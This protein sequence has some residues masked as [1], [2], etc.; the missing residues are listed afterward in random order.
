M[1]TQAFLICQIAVPGDVGRQA[2]ELQDLP[3]LHGDPVAGAGA[4]SG[5]RPDA[6]VRSAAIGVGPG[7][8]G[9]SQDL[10][11]GQHGRPPPLQVPAI[12]PVKRA[13]PQADVVADQVV[14]D[15]PD[16]ADLVVLVEDQADDLA[17]LL[18]GVH[19]DPF[20]G[21]LDV[22]G[23]HAVKEFAALG[24]V[25]P[26]SLQSI[27]HSNKLKFADGSFQTEQEAC[28]WY[29]AGRRRRPR[30][31]GSFRRW[32]TSPKDCANPCCC[33]RCGSSRSRGSGR[34]APW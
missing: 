29:P 11:D 16:G 13:N 33:G 8:D 9:V 15:A 17:D 34:H 1:L 19:L 4:F 5:G 27:P 3:L 6:L 10:K 24:L 26:A 23:G 32:H 30:R 28:R 12:G 14:E 7:V 31:P 22:A 2:I 21:E 25:Q 18:V 20:R